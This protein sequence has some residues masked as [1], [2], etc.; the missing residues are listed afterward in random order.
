[1]ER[2][3]A[4]QS[5][6]ELGGPGSVL[7]RQRRDHEELDRLMARHRTTTGDEQAEALNG[8][9][10]LA[11]SHAF[12]EEAVLWP[13]IRRAVPD[14]EALTLRIE[15]EHQEINELTAALERTTPGVR[16]DELTDQLLDLL[17]T[18]VRDEEDLVLPRLQRA[19]GPDELRAL[20]RR[21]EVVRRIAPTRPHPVVSRRPPGNVL[22]ALPLSIIDRS[23]DR[24]DR[25]A[26][27]AGGPVAGASRSA[28][29]ALAAVAGGIERIPAMQ[30]GE[31]ATTR[32]GRTAEEG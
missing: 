16:R 11:F 19:V 20:G 14:G 13:V 6:A 22:S 2:S 18:D 23:R 29:R 17:D 8:I 5:E 10:R 24:L 32:A 25:A 31:R 15:Q 27:R 4:D 28:S 7:V 30:Q 21:W 9:T 3:I 1:V 12:A 26:R